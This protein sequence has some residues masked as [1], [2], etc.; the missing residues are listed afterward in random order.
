MFQDLIPAGSECEAR[1]REGYRGLS[2]TP[3]TWRAP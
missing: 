3:R 2:R 1:L